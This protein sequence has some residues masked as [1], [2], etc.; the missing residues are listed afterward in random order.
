[1]N[2]LSTSYCNYNWFLLDKKSCILYTC[3]K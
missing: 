3:F 2:N 1:M